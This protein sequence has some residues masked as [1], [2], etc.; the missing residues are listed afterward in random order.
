M[1]KITKDIGEKIRFYREFFYHGVMEHFD[2]LTQIHL[3]Y[4]SSDME[5]VTIT[6]LG[7][8]V[9]AACKWGT[10]YGL[11]FRPLMPTCS[12]I[13]LSKAPLAENEE[14]VQRLKIGKEDIRI[15]KQFNAM[16]I[17]EQIL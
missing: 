4:Q 16:T 2:S 5:Q 12:K 10:F 13:L 11:S 7:T 8:F 9:D 3:R 6:I 15:L 14:L 17:L 1:E